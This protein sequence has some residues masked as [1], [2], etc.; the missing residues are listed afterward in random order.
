MNLQVFGPG[1]KFS[2]SWKRTGERFLPSMDPD[3][4]GLLIKGWNYVGEVIGHLSFKTKDIPIAAVSGVRHIYSYSR[5]NV[6]A[7]K[8][9]KLIAM[10]S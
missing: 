9:A 6:L 2:A 10:Y 8:Q 4:Q 5:G 3:N 1:E 7:N